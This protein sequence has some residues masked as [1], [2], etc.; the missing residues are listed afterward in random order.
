M[1]SH[2]IL[3]VFGPTTLDDAKAVHA[4]ICSLVQRALLCSEAYEIEDIQHELRLWFRCLYPA[5][6]ILNQEVKRLESE[7]PVLVVAE[8]FAKYFGLAISKKGQ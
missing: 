4:A 3:R 6:Q 1:T 5:R 2:D 8:E 7:V